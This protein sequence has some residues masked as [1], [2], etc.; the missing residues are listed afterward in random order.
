MFLRSVFVP[1]F[2]FVLVVL[3]GTFLVQADAECD[4]CFFTSDDSEDCKVYGKIDDQLIPWRKASQACIDFYGNNVASIDPF[5]V[6]CDPRSVNTFVNSGISGGNIPNS[7]LGGLGVAEGG[8]FV[9]Q[10]GG[11]Y[12][13]KDS[14]TVDG[15][16]YD[17]STSASTCYNAMKTYFQTTSNGA[18]E[19]D[20]VCTQIQNR[21]IN[22]REVE[23]TTLRNRLCREIK[24]E[25]N[26]LD[27]SCGE[28]ATQVEARVQAIPNESCP[29]YAF[30]TENTVVPGCE[31]QGSTNDT[32][33]D[34][35]GTTS[36]SPIG[37]FSAVLSLSSSLITA[38]VFMLE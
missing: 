12:G 33:N 35:D 11:Q 4:K 10:Q 15:V 16:T 19:M 18:G 6:G 26:T 27:E 32:G 24:E 3:L 7:V 21:I 1:S 28:L 2:S 37:M 9:Q 31:G 5:S 29:N 13:L 38:F 22:D 36:S 25:G 14:I 20:D 34:N 30:G 8:F 17:C 23:Q